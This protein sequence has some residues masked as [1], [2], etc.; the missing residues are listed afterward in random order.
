[1]LAL[2]EWSLQLAFDARVGCMHLVQITLA[3]HTVS[4]GP[5]CCAGQPADQQETN[6]P[7][8]TAAAAALA[9]PAVSGIADEAFQLKVLQVVQ[10][11]VACTGKPLLL[12]MLIYG[13]TLLY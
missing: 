1:M 10:R 9:A 13:R 3:S 7:A 4:R 11:L 12:A 5:L 8:L 2:A 6:S